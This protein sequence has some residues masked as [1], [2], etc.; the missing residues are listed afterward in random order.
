MLP[1]DNA[2]AAYPT[3]GGNPP[4]LRSQPVRPVGQR[5]HQ[6]KS[7]VP[8]GKTGTSTDRSSAPAFLNRIKRTARLASTHTD[9]S[10]T[11]RVTRNGASR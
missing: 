3:T 9:I 4:R 5:A 1:T 7:T 11:L 2:S 8:T 10:F 6:E